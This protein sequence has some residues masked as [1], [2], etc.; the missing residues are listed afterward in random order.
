MSNHNVTFRVVPLTDRGTRNLM[1]PLFSNVEDNRELLLEVLGEAGAA[2]TIALMESGHISGAY[3]EFNLLPGDEESGF[4]WILFMGLGARQG[5]RTS[6]RLHDRLR[7]LVAIAARHYRRKRRLTFA[8]PDMSRIVEEHIAGRLIAEGAI[9]GLYRFE[10]YKSEGNRKYQ[11]GR[12]IEAIHVLSGASSTLL[13]RQSLEQG[14]TMGVSVCMARDLVNTP[15]LDLTPESFADEAER[16]A[17][18]TP[19]LEFEKLSRV[20]MEVERLSL[21]LAVAR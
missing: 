9:L 5:I 21:H 14:S 15:A 6:Y 2:R 11:D 16:V 7:S 13:L 12:N 17:R 20:H 1:V 10:R 4:E 3:K 8:V 19:G 18:L